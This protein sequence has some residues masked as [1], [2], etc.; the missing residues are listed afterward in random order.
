MS[1]QLNLR[2]PALSRR[3]FLKGLGTLLALPML[4]AMIPTRG[5]AST[6]P[7]PKR[8]LF[9][10][11]PNGFIMEEWGAMQSGVGLSLSRIL[12][13]LTPFQSEL[14][15]LSNLDNYPSSPQG[16]GP[17]QHA[18]GTGS[19][20]T[21]HHIYKTSGTD[22][23]NGV[24]LDQ[25][26][27]EKMAGT[28]PFRSLELGTEPGYSAGTCDS[29]YSC[30]YSQNIAWSGPST[31][32]SKEISPQALFNRLFAGTNANESEVQKQRRLLYQQSIL[33]SV[34]A[35]AAQL[36][37]HLGTQDR[38]KLDEYLTGIRELEQRLNAPP[39]SCS[40]AT[41]APPKAVDR[42]E[43]IRQMSDLMTLAFQCD[44]TRIITF[45]FANAASHQTFPWLGI[46]D[47]HHVI[48][49]HMDD[50]DTIE[51]LVQIGI[52]E[53]SMVAYLLQKLQSVQEGEGTLLDNTLVYFSSE[54]ADGNAHTYTNM[55][56]MLAGRMGGT[57]Q[58]GRCLEY[59]AGTPIANLLIAL[60][61][62]MELPL[63]TFGDDGVSPLDGLS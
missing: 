8:V 52:W 54:I 38:Q 62:R 44:M 46:N 11:V 4:D 18:R 5:S 7:F 3:T 28:T 53:M 47:Y 35:D 2:R 29:G 32:L 39:V 59:A 16:E 48:S 41:Q 27:A 21:A 14:L 36:H 19:F 24:S 42:Q 56:V 55:P 15:F 51:K 45:M 13:P 20:L 10:Y 60:A 50:P 34:S 25:L 17:G 22:I 30:T 43:L 12:E 57:I 26:L 40:G 49:H 23:Y 31:P 37:Q 9:Y 58:P 63:T 33:D 1:F 6:Q 61:Q